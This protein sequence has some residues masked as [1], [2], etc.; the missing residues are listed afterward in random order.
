MKK[1]LLTAM[2]LAVV[3]QTAIA[4]TSPNQWG[5]IFEQGYMF[6]Y[7]TNPKNN[8]LRITCNVSNTGDN[9]HD[10][11]IESDFDL[12]ESQFAYDNMSDLIFQFDGQVKM[13]LSNQDTK[14]PKGSMQWTQFI[15]KIHQAK[16]IDVFIDNKKTATF[17][18]T[19]S[20][21]KYDLKSIEKDC[22]P[23]LLW[24]D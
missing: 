16:Q 3:S 2:I 18:P 23:M 22:R 17:Y 7:L 24:Q 6:Y 9:E 12:A 4:K 11:A 20:S 14:S 5:N 10:V 21:K 19:A 15:K 13:Q 1:S 8:V